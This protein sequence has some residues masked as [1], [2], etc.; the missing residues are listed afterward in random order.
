MAEKFTRDSL[1]APILNLRRSKSTKLDNIDQMIDWRP[2]RKKLEKSLKRSANAAGKPAYP[3]LV[4]FKCLVLQRMYNLSDEGLEEQLGDRLSFLRFVGLDVVDSVPDATT[5]CRFRNE[6]LGNK[7]MEKLF[8]IIL[9]QLARQG[10]FQAGICVDATVIASARRPKTTLEVIPEDRKESDEP[11]VV[12]THSDDKEAAWLKKGKKTHYGY[13]AHVASDPDTGLVISGHL[14]PANKSDM[15]GLEKVLDNLP[16]K[17]TGRCYADK[18]YSSNENR[19]IIQKHGLKE[20][21]MK[22]ACRNKALKKW[23]RIRN[24]CISS[25]RCGIERIFGCFKRNLRF[26]R[27]RYIGLAKVEQEFYLVAICYNLIRGRTLCFS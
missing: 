23:E 8:S 10:K 12:I 1:F 6:L 22:K 4:M 16:D 24:K 15:K 7:M 3:G 13:K 5:I 21:I 17:T 9:G 27:S 18:G 2:V 25:I 14:T 20:A 11:D 19:E 26:D